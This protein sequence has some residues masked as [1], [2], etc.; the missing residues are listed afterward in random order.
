VT[1]VDQPP[2]RTLLEQLVRTS[3][4]TIEE[5]CAAFERTAA[6]H[7]ENATL[8]PRQL[9][10]WMTAETTSARPVAQR[11]AE[12]HWGHPFHVLLGP[13]LSA[14]QLAVRRTGSGPADSDSDGNGPGFGPSAIAHVERL[15]QGVHDAVSTGALAAA[16]S[17]ASPPRSPD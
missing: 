9:W 5:N 8:S 7:G 16:G 13:P 17:P 11:V 4:R 6:A 10:R 1:F 15:R 12:L 14:A 2:P 3:R